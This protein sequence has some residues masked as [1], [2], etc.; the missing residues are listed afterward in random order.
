MEKP[1]TSIYLAWALCCAGLLAAGSAHAAEHVVTQK[2]KAFSVKK[3]AVKVGDTI[4]FVNEDS[5]AHNV[6]SLSAP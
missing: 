3:L 6:F 2:N 1:N 4:K 5:F